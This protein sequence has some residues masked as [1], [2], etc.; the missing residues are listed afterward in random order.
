[1]DPTGMSEFT[2]GFA[3]LFDQTTQHWADLRAAPILPS[4]RQEAAD[5]WDAHLPL[6]GTDY[7]YQFK[8]CEHLL[9]PY[10]KYRKDGTYDAP[11]FRFDIYRRHNSRQ[12]NRLV[13][14]SQNHPHTYY[15]APEFEEKNEFT[16]AF[17]ARQ[18]L[19]WSRLIPLHDCPT[20]DDNAAHCITYQRGN[21][22]WAWHSTPLYRHSAVFG[23]DL[24]RFYGSSRSLWQPVD[25]G[26]ARRL[27]ESTFESIMKACENNQERS[28]FSRRLIESQNMAESKAELLQV[29]A[30][31]VSV[32]FGLTLVLVGEASH[33]EQ[34]EAAQ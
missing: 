7:Y 22:D 30:D 18:M 27:V 17:Q 12:H 2:F 10:A 33:P 28:Y 6:N 32:V 3:F 31:A 34:T 14:H 24:E 21:N 20:I 16:D 26:F 19:A 8:L 1:M 15:V 5:A 13:I 11:Y 4:L 25:V 23:K 9:R 29:A